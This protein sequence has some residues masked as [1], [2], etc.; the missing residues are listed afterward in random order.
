MCESVPEGR[1]SM[2]VFFVFRNRSG[3]AWTVNEYNDNAAWRDSN[4][5]VI[6]AMSLRLST[7]MPLRCALCRSM[8]AARDSLHIR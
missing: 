7:G 2:I 3:R 6:S 4:F 5:E 8:S 1:L